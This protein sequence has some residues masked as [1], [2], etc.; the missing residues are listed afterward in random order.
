MKTGTNPQ[1]DRTFRESTQRPFKK[2]SQVRSIRLL[3]GSPSHEHPG[4]SPQTGTWH[5]SCT[6]EKALHPR[7]RHGSSAV[8]NFSLQSLHRGQFVNNKTH[9]SSLCRHIFLKALPCSGPSTHLALLVFLARLVLCLCG[10][11]RSRIRRYPSPPSPVAP[12]AP[13]PVAPA[14]CSCTRSDRAD[15]RP[16]QSPGC[17]SHTPGRAS[18]PRA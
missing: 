3:N 12:R 18:R 2:R 14:R 11:S 5:P 16:P 9:C 4:P 13:P 10:L 6:K 8:S 1:S 7:C 15:R 17:R